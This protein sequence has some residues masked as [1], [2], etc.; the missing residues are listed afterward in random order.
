[1][2][3]TI[4]HNGFAVAR[5]T[6][7]VSTLRSAA[8]TWRAAS[9]LDSNYQ[10]HSTFDAP[11]RKAMPRRRPRVLKRIARQPRRL[12]RYSIAALLLVS[13]GFTAPASSHEAVSEPLPKR[14]NYSTGANRG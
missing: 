11:S 7:T 14:L 12:I 8:V 5:E 1:M 4:T 2:N 3:V 10:V 9:T 13:A 6:A